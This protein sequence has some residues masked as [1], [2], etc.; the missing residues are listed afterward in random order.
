[1]QGTKVLSISKSTLK[2]TYILFPSDIRE[3]QKIGTYFRKLDELIA[4]HAIQLEKLKQLKS[5]C[6]AKMFV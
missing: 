3:Q 1:M 6:L 4:N 2:N 5:A